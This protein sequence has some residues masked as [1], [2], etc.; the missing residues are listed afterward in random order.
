MEIIIGMVT[1]V[2]RQDSRKCMHTVV[3]LSKPLM[4]DTSP[5]SLH[6]INIAVTLFIMANIYSHLVHI[7]S[8]HA[9][10]NHVCVVHNIGLVIVI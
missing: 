5:I 3:K 2:Q 6:N 7:H 4:H 1:K 9:T 8:I 10:G